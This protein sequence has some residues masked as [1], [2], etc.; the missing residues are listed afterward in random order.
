MNPTSPPL[1]PVATSGQRTR[2]QRLRQAAWGQPKRALGWAAGALILSSLGVSFMVRSAATPPSIP[3]IALSSTPLYAAT[4]IDKPSLA[5]ALSVEFPTVGAQYT[6]DSS[7]DSSYSNTTEYLGYYDAESCYTYND[8]PT[9]TPATGLTTT[10][11]KRFDRSGA[12]VNRKCTNAFS[13][14]FLNWAS[15]SAIDMLRLALS[16]GDR[17]I[18]QD[19]LTILQRAVLPNGDP[20]CFWNTRNFPAKQLT[21]NGGGAGTYW[22]AVPTAMITAADGNDIYVA[23]TLN[24]IYFGTTATGN[25]WS[26]Q[27]D[28]NLNT[29]LTTSS[30]GPIANR[31]QNRPTATW[32]ANENGTCSFTGTKEVWYGAGNRWKVAPAANGVACTNGVF[33]DP[34]SGTAKACYIRDY[35]GTWTPPAGRGTQLNS[36]GF[37]YSRVQ[38]CQKTNGVLSDVRDYGLC[39]LYPSGNYKPSG[40]IQKYSDQL[41]LAAFGYLMDQTASYNNGRYGGV[42]RA[43]MKYVGY[44][45]FDENG[46]DTT[47]STGNANMEWDN[48]TGVFKA[49]P[50]GDTSFGIS[51]VINYLNKF[52][53]TGPVAGRYKQYD[54]VGELHYETLRYLQGLSPSADAISGINDDLKDGFPV[55]TTW[56]DPYGG[57]RSASADYSCV[58]SNIVVVGDINTHDG[59]RLPT[60]S[61]ANNIIDINAWRSVVQNFERNSTTSTYVDGQGVT[62]YT[63]NPN[64]SNGGV[65]SGSSTSQIMGTAYWSHTHDIR[66]STWTN[67]PSK[68]RP[69][70]RVK[71]YLFDVNEYGT[72]TDPN[73]RRYSNQFFMA[74]KYGGF[75]TDASN[76]GGSPY[77]TWGNPFRNQAGTVDNNVW[78]DPDN[79]GEA[80]TY[81]LQSSARGVLS[82][83]DGI[84]SRAANSSRNIAGV[85]IQSREVSATVDNV[86]Y[87]G[88]FDTSSWT[89]D[90]LAL[91]L[92]VVGTSTLTLSSQADWSAADKLTNRANPSTTRTIVMG[93]AGATQTPAA[94]DF[95]WGSLDTT[96]QGYLNKASSNAAADGLGA[97][98]VAY[99][100]GD[101][102]LE[103][104]T[105]RTRSKLLGDIINSSVVFS[106]TPTTAYTENSY[107]TFYTTNKNRTPAVFV[108]ANDGMLHA[109]NASKG[110]NGG[111]ELFAYIPSWMGPNLSALTST[112]YNN[113]HQSY[114]DGVP[115]VAEACVGPS[116]TLTANTCTWKTVLVS[117]TGAGGPGVFALDVTDPTAFSASKVMWE[118]TKADD[119]DMGYVVGTPQIL[120]MRMNADKDGNGAAQPATYRWFAVVASGVNNY[121]TDSAGR[122]SATG[123]PALFFLALDKAVGDA[124]T[125]GTNYYKVQLPFDSTLAT[126]KATG[127]ANFTA[128]YGASGEV[129]YLFAGDLHGKLWKLD[130]TPRDSTHPTSE[131]NP[132]TSS[133][134][135]MARLSFFNKGTKAS[136]VAYPMYIAQDGATTPNLQPIFSAPRIFTGPVVNGKKTYYVLF[137]TG[138][139]LE[140]SDKTST[141]KNSIYTVFD[142]GVTGL[143]QSDGTTSSTTASVISGRGRLQSGTVNTSTYVITVPAFLWG[144]ATA[145][146]DTTQRSGWYFDLPA[147]GEKMISS[148]LSLTTYATFNTIIPG[149]AGASGSCTATPGSGNSYSVNITTGNGSY[150]PSSVGLLGSTMYVKNSGLIVPGLS[151]STGRKIRTITYESISTGS[152]GSALTNTKVEIKEAYGRLSWRQVN[153]YWDLHQKATQ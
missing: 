139:F 34:I 104:T 57:N 88:A 150:I 82:A 145:D 30:I 91:P 147:S 41:R 136:P 137:G 17:Y 121:V 72:Q 28:Y 40:V 130:F 135:T 118:F 111:A 127:V 86:I 119:A 125:Q 102:S 140:A 70:L 66:P 146:N 108:G 29:V 3:A 22:G 26:G 61:D 84:F 138:K 71:N 110:T 1:D 132:G 62:R 51:G 144:R 152:S 10:D 81:F 76:T 123:N 60:P 106:G 126:S 101:R 68:V 117:G 37:F 83:F 122:F 15:S 89:G 80:A 11:Y 103:G 23:N 69:G 31:N 116:H 53:R 7:N 12:A 114:V 58:R 32:C 27:S 19:G 92:T 49:N 153:N 36:D 50:D 48:T 87:Q 13:G 56:T 63:G 85:A 74:S 75:E 143:S 2:W 65:P 95:I 142:N 109:F 124:W 43:P 45:V 97:N 94:T 24:R 79:P 141:A 107:S 5:L 33:G 6:T 20:S 46:N 8:A 100:R 113:N 35:T 96:T 64:G 14:N 120:K 151:D 90:V 131:F 93:R 129:T 55:Y 149:S 67:A 59:N 98:R 133:H 99:L 16:G 52:G 4:P 105:F 54:P 18:D 39:K 112:S 9:E 115:T 148:F 44:K 77:N 42:L 73:N 38:V 78:Q 134:W 128:M 47:P 25:C 21:R